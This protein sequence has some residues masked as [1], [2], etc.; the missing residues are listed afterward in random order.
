[1]KIRNTKSGKTKEYTLGDR[2]D[3]DHQRMQQNYCR[4]L[5]LNYFNENSVKRSKLVPVL[6]GKCAF[7]FE[8]VPVEAGVFWVYV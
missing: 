2:G 3:L 6:S 1:M 8:R 5:G 4:C 7:H